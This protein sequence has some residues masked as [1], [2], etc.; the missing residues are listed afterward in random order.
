MQET[1]LADDDAPLLPFRGMGYDLLHHGEG[2]WNGVAIASRVPIDPASVVT[3]FGDGPVR[4]SGTGTGPGSA[5]AEEDFN[6]FVEARMLSAVID[7][8]RYVS[9][10]APNGRIV[11][12]PFYEGKLAWFERLSRWLAENTSPTEQLVVGGDLNGRRPRS[13]SDGPAHGGT[14]EIGTQRERFRAARVGPRRWL[15]VEAA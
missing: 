3:N 9:L 4:N 12:S 2:R 13:M 15:P 8:I 5:F 10:Y 7:G 1:K 6:P 11:G 14:S